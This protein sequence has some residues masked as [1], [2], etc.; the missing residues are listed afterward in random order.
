MRLSLL[1]SFILSLLVS[2]CAVT[3]IVNRTVPPDMMADVHVFSR[4]DDRTANLIDTALATCFEQ[5]QEAET[6]C[7]ED[8]LARSTL[9][10][11][12][13]A[14]MMPPCRVGTVCTYDHTTR[15][16]LGL[17]A[18][19]ATLVVKDWRVSFDLRSPVASV[20]LVPVTVTDR[21]VFVVPRPTTPTVVK[22]APPVQRL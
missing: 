6:H 3:E 2:G 7:V 21:N 14:A 19:Y 20:A 8:A 18:S 17:L 11:R 1:L 9:S 22:S 13:L 12:D 10:L 5:T 4:N 16:R 15:R